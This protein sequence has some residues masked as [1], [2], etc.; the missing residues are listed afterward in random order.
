MCIHGICYKNNPQMYEKYK[1]KEYPK[2]SPSRS[3]IS[4]SRFFSFIHEVLRRDCLISH[5]NH[6]FTVNPNLT[7]IIFTPNHDCSGTYLKVNLSIISKTW[8]NVQYGP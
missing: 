5:D 2:K 4:F 7:Q 6:F 3:I 1:Q 8:G